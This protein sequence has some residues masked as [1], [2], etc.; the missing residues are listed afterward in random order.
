MQWTAEK[1]QELK[2]LWSEPGATMSTIAKAMGV[3][4]NSIIG[5]S[6]RLG[7]SFAH[8][9]ATPLSI[10]DRGAAKAG[11]TA[12][13][14]RVMD[15]D[16]FVLKPGKYQRKLVSVV[17]KGLWTGFP[18]YSLTLEER[19]TCPKTCE[20]WQG[21]FGNHMHNASRYRHG[22]ALDV[23]IKRE[24][25]NLA[26]THPAGFVVRLHILGDFVSVPYVKMWADLLLTYPALHIFG[27]THW[28]RG[29]EIGD[30][31]AKL[32]DAWW[33]RFAIRTSD[34]NASE[35]PRTVVIEDKSQLPRGAIICPAQVGVGRTCSTC[36]LCWSPAAKNKTIAFLRH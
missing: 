8:N 16:D 28:K 2:D 1:K 35:G 18:I 14:S 10:R 3:T 22:D 15:P 20:Q 13:P 17:K 26:H 7:L 25:A 34:A 9:G 19:A 31:V 32:R 4:R 30:A 12:Y 11:H 5:A 29:T 36:A 23:E 33:W 24:V 27:Y 21:C 6:N